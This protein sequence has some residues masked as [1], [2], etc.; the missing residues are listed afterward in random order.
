MNYSKEDLAIVAKTIY[1]EARGEFC[2]F[3]LSSLIAIANVIINRYKKHFAKSLSEVCLAPYQFSCWNKNDKNY[4][5]IQ[6][7][8]ENSEIYKVCLRVA[9]NTLDSTWPD[10]TDGCD[11]YHEKSIRP[12][13]ASRIIPK[14][15][16]GNHCFYS[17]RED[18]E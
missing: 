5:A 15:V 2:P 14:R 10:L 12:Y 4:K 3:G 13:W 17:L 16:F 6:H 9:K 11:H 8:N 1:G 7:I 18:N